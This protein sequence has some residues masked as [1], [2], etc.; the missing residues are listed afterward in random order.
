LGEAW[1]TVDFFAVTSRN[2]QGSL[3]LAMNRSPVRACLAELPDGWPLLLLRMRSAVAWL[4]QPP[5][6]QAIACQPIGNR[7]AWLLALIPDPGS[8]PQGPLHLAVEDGWP[9]LRIG[10]H[11]HLKP[12][13]PFRPWSW[14][15]TPTCGCAQFTVYVD[16]TVEEIQAWLRANPHLEPSDERNVSARKGA[17]SFVTEQ[18]R[19][20]TREQAG[21]DQALLACLSEGALGELSFDLVDTDYGSLCATGHS[22][23]ELAAY[24]DPAHLWSNNRYELTVRLKPDQD[25]W[26]TIRLAITQYAGLDAACGLNVAVNQTPIERLPR[27]LTVEVPLRMARASWEYP[28][29]WNLRIRTHFRTIYPEGVWELRNS[30]RGGDRHKHTQEELLRDLRNAFG[31][32]VSIEILM[33]GALRMRGP[34][35]IGFAEFAR[36]PLALLSESYELKTRSSPRSSQGLLVELRATRGLPYSEIHTP[37]ATGPEGWEC[38]LRLDPTFIREI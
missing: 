4:D 13:R 32:G 31:E 36:L 14:K 6:R 38:T 2:L 30:L 10:N 11:A 37:E 15:W 20:L 27:W 33:D 29:P 3:L 1:C 8:F 25:P 22:C 5:N 12:M 28:E 18:Y 9:G 17:L 34:R 19:G 26:E 35:A 7:K 24:L 21:Y 16:R 23:A